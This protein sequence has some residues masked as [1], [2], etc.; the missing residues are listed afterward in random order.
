MEYD[1]VRI[2]WVVLLAPLVTFCFIYYYHIY[3]AT[4]CIV[5]T[6]HPCSTQMTYSES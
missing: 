6:L 2:P 1:C 4:H 5:V 3:H